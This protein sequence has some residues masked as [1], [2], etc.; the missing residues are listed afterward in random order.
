MKPTTKSDA[1][2]PYHRYAGT[3]RG[4]RA[5][6]AWE[7]IGAPPHLLLVMCEPWHTLDAYQ[8]C[9]G[10]VRVGGGEQEGR[11]GEGWRREGEGE[12]GRAGKGR[13]PICLDP[14][15]FLLLLAHHL[16][17]HHTQQHM[18]WAHSSTS[19]LL[20]LQLPPYH[21][22]PEEV[23]DPRLYADNVRAYMVGG[24]WEGCRR[25]G[26]GGGG[27]RRVEEGGEG[28]RRVGREGCRRVEE[29]CR[30]VEEGGRMDGPSEGGTEELE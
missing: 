11:R 9:V 2:V 20:L 25:V 18:L 10:C 21:P 1:W 22:S 5:S 12:E 19:C 3:R 13:C 6:P 28:W 29:G 16:C 15:A 8:V 30:R 26:R 4:A 27:W 23:A 7:S 14:A 17:S 24:V